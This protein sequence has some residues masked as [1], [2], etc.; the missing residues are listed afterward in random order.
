MRATMNA[1]FVFAAHRLLPALLPRDC[2][3]SRS[4]VYKIFRKLQRDGV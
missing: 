3:P 2:F 4:T 1:I